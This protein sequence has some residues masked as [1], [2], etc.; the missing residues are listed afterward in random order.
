MNFYNSSL[1]Y[2]LYKIKFLYMKNTQ[3]YIHGNIS[4]KIVLILITIKYIKLY[5]N[6][7]LKINGNTIQL[8]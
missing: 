4:F 8:I 6:N 5:L 7:T 2:N 1:L 3:C